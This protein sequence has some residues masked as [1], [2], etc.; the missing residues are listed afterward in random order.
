MNDIDRN[1]RY[2]TDF[3]PFIHP[4]QIPKPKGFIRKLFA[5]SVF[6]YKSIKK[7]IHEKTSFLFLFNFPNNFQVIIEEYL[8]FIYYERKLYDV[9]IYL[10]L[11]NILN[12]FLLA[13][14]YD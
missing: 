6:F 12:Y 8:Q 7:I 14:C 3:N 11:L 1:N 13:K 2:R 9:T 10:C 5:V 4:S